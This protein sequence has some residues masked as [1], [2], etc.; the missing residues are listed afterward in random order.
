MMQLMLSHM[1]VKPD[2][3]KDA[4]YKYLFTVE[5]MNKLVNE[6]MAYRDAYRQIGTDV[7]AGTFTF[8]FEAL[9]HIHEGSI[10]NLCNQEI[11]LQMAELLN[12]FN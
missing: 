10:G 12:K 8:N 3:L 1:V 5:A 6:G 4:K 7:E 11:A 2:L 9:R